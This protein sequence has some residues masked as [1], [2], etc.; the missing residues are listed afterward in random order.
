MNVLF[1]MVAFILTCL[2]SAGVY[3]IPTATHI[4]NISDA[5]GN[6]PGGTHGLWTNRAMGS[7][8]CDANYFS[9]SGTLTQFDN[10]TATLFAT[11]V[12]PDSVEAVIDFTFGGY[13]ED[14]TTL[15]L[16]NG[17]GASP[18]QISDWVFYTTIDG[19]ITID[20]LGSFDALGLT[21]GHGLQIGWG[22]NDK[23]SD[24]GASVWLDMSGGHSGGKHW[25][26]NMDLV[27]QVPEPSM[28]L[29]LSTGLIGFALVRRK[30]S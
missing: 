23:T 8:S 18:A 9:I 19:S 20:G 16:K 21:G 12:N 10:G 24:F 1:K 4:W 22:A 3:A 5:A 17:G 28:L 14:H 30:N 25:D 27:A 6:C 11:A 15:P 2:F 7:P 29:L 13:T 26:I